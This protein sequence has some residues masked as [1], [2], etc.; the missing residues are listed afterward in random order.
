MNITKSRLK[1]IIQEEL[2]S[3]SLSTFLAARA[4]RRAAKR[5][6]EEKS[7][8]V[9]KELTEKEIEVINLVKSNKDLVKAAIQQLEMTS[10]VISN[11]NAENEEIS[12]ALKD[13]DKARD[14]INALIIAKQPAYLKRLEEEE[15][16]SPGEAPPENLDDLI[17][18]AMRGGI[19]PSGGGAEQFKKD[20]IRAVKKELGLK[21]GSYGGEGSMADSQLNRIVE[22]AIMID[23][24]VSDKTNLPEWVESK[25]TKSQDYLSG[26]LNYMRGE[27]AD[28]REEMMEEEKLTKPQIKKRDKHAKEI[29]KST[30]KQ[31]GKKEGE[32]IAYAIAT[33]QVKEDT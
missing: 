21:E 19:S 17:Q 5:K 29:M 2:Q 6:G 12:K 11:P 3:E 33:N 26:V 30:K 4:K 23:D 1:E 7:R 24:L 32:D 13:M 14:A 10:D 18:R 16:R 15:R 20:I 22:L 9:P 8:F 28:A 27:L 25:I 31:Y